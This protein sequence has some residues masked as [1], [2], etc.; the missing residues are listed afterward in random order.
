M[1][2]RMALAWL[3]GQPI[4]FGESR[5]EEDNPAQRR[6][7][8]HAIGTMQKYDPLLYEARFR[9][10]LGLRFPA[11]VQ[12]TVF[13]APEG[14]LLV[15]FVNRSAQK[16]KI[17]IQTKVLIPAAVGTG[18]DHCRLM[19]LHR[20]EPVKFADSG[21]VFSTSLPPETLGLLRLNEREPK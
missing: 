4:R 5:T 8:K 20:N 13:V 3:T 21:G 9:D 10:R 2:K 12:A 19:T 6:W 14:Q 7:L 17:A 18:I 15:C 11:Q 16:Q 1:R